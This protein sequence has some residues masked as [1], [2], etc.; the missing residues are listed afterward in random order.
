MFLAQ[1]LF[2][3]CLFGQRDIPKDTVITLERTE[4][5]GTCPSYKLSILA[6]G[7]VVF[8]GERNVKRVGKVKGR[9]NQ[10]HLK[11]LLAEFER[12]NYF[13]LKDDYGMS[14]GFGPLPTEE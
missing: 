6:N 4:C 8:V 3:L 12:I 7:E 2:L 11:Q 5:Y 1:M 10:D 9:I 14:G 13:S